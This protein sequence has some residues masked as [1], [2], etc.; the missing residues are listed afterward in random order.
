MGGGS[1]VLQ[2]LCYSK[3]RE[4]K[5]EM[6]SRTTINQSAAPGPFTLPLLPH[7]GSLGSVSMLG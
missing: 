3:T 7:L 5:L 4:T 1:S 2:L 6:V